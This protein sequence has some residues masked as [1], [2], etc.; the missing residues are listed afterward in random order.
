M[1][2]PNALR[3]PISRIRSVDACQHDVHDSDPADEQADRRDDPATAPRILDPHMDVIDRLL[4]RGKAEILDAVVREHQ[5]ITR[6]LQCRAELF[7]VL[8]LQI[9][10]AERGVGPAIGARG[11]AKSEPHA[12]ERNKHRVVFPPENIPSPRGSV[13]IFLL[14]RGWLRRISLGAAILL[15][16]IVFKHSNDRERL[17]IN[18]NDL[19]YRIDRM[20]GFLGGAEEVVANPG[21][22]HAD[23]AGIFFIEVRKKAAFRE[24][25]EV[26]VEHRWPDSYNCDGEVVFPRVRGRSI[27]QRHFRRDKPQRFFG[28]L[29]LSEMTSRMVIAK[30]RA[31]IPVD[32]IVVAVDQALVVERHEDLQHRADVA[33]VEREALVL[34]VARRAQA[35]EL[36]DDRVAV[37][38]APAPHALDERLA[39]D[40]LAARPLGLPQPL[41][42]RLG[43][44]AGVVGAEDPLRLPL[45]IRAKRISVSW[46]EPSSAWPMCSA[47]VTFGG[48]IAIE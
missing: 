7:D 22:N 34:V 43:R 16:F 6:L 2:A 42:L 27:S 17:I 24:F 35:L 38:L 30:A 13:L 10:V 45:C 32:E 11:R 39:P 36:V 19:T 3:I 1:V 40:L 37:L 15:A 33:V 9:N 21:A 26:H 23:R 5:N 48:G 20:A 41:D 18:F 29:L 44:D 8:D 25:V 4:L 31:G 14:V 47:P 12:I 46:I 28:A